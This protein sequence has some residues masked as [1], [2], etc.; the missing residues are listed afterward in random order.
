MLAILMF[1]EVRTG[2]VVPSR[3]SEKE[4]TDSLRTPLSST[5]PSQIGPL[6]PREVALVTHGPTAGWWL[7]VAARE[8][9]TPS[10]LTALA[11]M[12]QPLLPQHDVQ[13]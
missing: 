4:E 8:W 3:L 11:S 2:H 7:M 6:K 10:H 9:S 1:P 12:V 13:G 5:L